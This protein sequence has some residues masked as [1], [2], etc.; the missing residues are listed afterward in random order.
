M[1]IGDCLVG[2]WFAQVKYNNTDA[3]V[4]SGFFAAW[5]GLREAAQYHVEDILLN[6]CKQCNRV[7]ATGHSLG[8]AISGRDKERESV[9]VC[10]CVSVCV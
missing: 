3:R 6:K 5:A 10:E 7:I 8:S 1:L 9:C 4:H 2:L